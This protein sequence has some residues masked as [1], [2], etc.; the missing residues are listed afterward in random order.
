MAVRDDLE[1]RTSF[2]LEFRLYSELEK[3][4]VTIYLEIGRQLIEDGYMHT[5]IQN[6][7]FYI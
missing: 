4:W 7:R 1:E 5:Y 3:N 6:Y 2:T